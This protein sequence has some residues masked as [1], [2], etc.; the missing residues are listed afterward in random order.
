MTKYKTNTKSDHKIKNNYATI[1]I[2]KYT[3]SEQKNLLNT[4]LTLMTKQYL[5]NKIFNLRP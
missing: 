2:T 5:K 3:L 1:Q 4:S